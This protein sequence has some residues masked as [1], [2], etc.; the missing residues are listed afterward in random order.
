MKPRLRLDQSSAQQLLVDVGMALDLGSHLHHIEGL[1][2][3]D[4]VA[5]RGPRERPAWK[6]TLIESR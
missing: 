2:L 3:R 1:Y 6:N 5:K 4:Q